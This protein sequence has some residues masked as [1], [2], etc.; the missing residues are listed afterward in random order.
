MK[1]FTKDTML[2]ALDLMQINSIASKD[3]VKTKYK[4]LCSAHKLEGGNEIIKNIKWAY[5]YIDKHFNSLKICFEIKQEIKSKFDLTPQSSKIFEQLIL[6][7]DLE[8]YIVGCWLWV[9][10]NTQAHTETLKGLGLYWH[11]KKQMWAYAGSKTKPK[12]KD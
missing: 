5:K 12:S 3:F 11:N 2:K 8:V 10:G 4:C 9:E 6:I 7:D 1:Y